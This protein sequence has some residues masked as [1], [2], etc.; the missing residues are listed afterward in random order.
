MAIDT[1]DFGQPVGAIVE[2]WRIP[3]RPEKRILTGKTCRL[4]PLNL[5]RHAD[6]LF[7][8]F[9]HD[10]QGKM[11]TYLPYGPFGSVDEY[12]AW[13][14]SR[15]LGDD[16]LFFAIVDTATNATT[17]VSAY[18][19]IEPTAG[20]IEV[21][22]LAYSPLLQRSRVATEAMY[23][24]MQYAFSLGYRRYEWKCNSL[25]K[26]SCNAALRLGFTFEGTFRQALV[27]NGRNRDTAWFSIIDSEW[28]LLDS[29]FG[30]WLD[31]ANFDASGRQRERLAEIIGSLKMR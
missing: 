22:H 12:R 18:L 13:I 8:A 6:D 15:A 19:R 30:R 5:D 1:N 20:S 27:V 28:P 3:A 4:E 31:D 9:S 7:A 24:M 14:I 29:A 10:Q 16:P 11:W 23:L 2:N 21:G 25:N 17:G 26:P